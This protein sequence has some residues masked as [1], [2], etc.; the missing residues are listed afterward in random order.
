MNS[1]E[2]ENFLRNSI[3]VV[4]NAREALALTRQQDINQVNKNDIYFSCLVHIVE[5]S[6]KW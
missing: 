6:F 2:R 4:D 1:K 5:L 3:L